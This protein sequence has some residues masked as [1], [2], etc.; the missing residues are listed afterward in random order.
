MY[1]GSYRFFFRYF[2]TDLC[3][4]FLYPPFL[5]FWAKP[6][7]AEGEFIDEVQLRKLTDCEH[8][9]L[10]LYLEIFKKKTEI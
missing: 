3:S 8:Y 5:A 4:T 1:C 6:E 7:A 9:Y 2:R 10:D